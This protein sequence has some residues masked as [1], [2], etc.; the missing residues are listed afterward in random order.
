MR[1]VARQVHFARPPPCVPRKNLFALSAVRSQRFG[2]LV[3]NFS[4]QTRKNLEPATTHNKW[5]HVRTQTTFKD[6]PPNELSREYLY[7]ENGD[8][9]ESITFF[10][11]KKHGP[12]VTYFRGSGNKVSTES[13]YVMDELD[14]R[15][16]LYYENGKL[17][18]EFYYKK[19]L[20]E[21]PYSCWDETGKI[22]EKS[23]FFKDRLHGISRSLYNGGTL[24]KED[25]YKNG[26]KDGICY[27]YN[28][29]GKMATKTVYIDGIEH[30]TT[31]FGYQRD[32][33]GEYPYFNGKLHGVLKTYYRNGKVKSETEYIYGEKQGEGIH[34][35]P[36]ETR[37]FYAMPP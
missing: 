8:A 33:Q 10:D 14:G 20:R 16:R 11:G 22:L 24:W 27:E 17:Q 36:D 29:D 12:H 32:L 35:P 6:I 34:Y 37:E 15:C 28:Q 4:P 18:Y 23:N 31:Y 25:S 30:G 3:A 2:H 21:G 7:F 9:K 1:P 26:K 19:G 13:E 5:K